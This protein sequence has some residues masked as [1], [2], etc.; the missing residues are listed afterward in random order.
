MILGA[1]NSISSLAVSC[2]L[3]CALSACISQ[4]APVPPG[5]IPRYAAPSQEDEQYGHKILSEL[6]K[7]YQLDY[8]HPRTPDV[9]KIV[10]KLAG[11]AHANGEPWHV[12]V[13]KDDNFKNAAASRGNHVFVWTGILN[14]T[15]D[16]DELAAII[17]HEMSHV[18]AKHTAK[19]PNEQVRQTLVQLGSLAAGMAAAYATRSSSWSSQVGDLASSATEEVAGGF[20]VNP[21]SREKEAEADQIGLFLMAD[22][23]YDPAAAVRFWQRAARDPSFGSS[24]A[25]FSTHPPAQERAQLLSTYL[26]Q[27]E[28]R[29]RGEKTSTN[30][31]A[32]A[33]YNR[34]P[35]YDLNASARQQVSSAASSNA[36]RSRSTTGGGLKSPAA[37]GPQVKLPSAA[38]SPASSSMPDPGDT[39]DMSKGSQTASPAAA[40]ASYQPAY[41]AVPIITQV[42]LQG[43]AKQS[44]S[45]QPFSTQSAGS[46]PG[47]DWIVVV[48]TA[49]LYAAPDQKSEVI[50]KFQ[51]STLIRV[52][53][54][55]KDWLEIAT[56]DH[57]Y[58]LLQQAVPLRRLDDLD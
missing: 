1:A 39:F 45:P 35:T 12:Y 32:G 14:A 48:P 53:S 19:D 5:E 34:A 42:D 27:A 52:L 24:L 16:N 41:K 17:A 6:T 9:Y 47:Q 15:Q 49:V 56:P 4:R 11:A 22:A 55:D 3:I 26:P 28:A 20:L 43:P 44:N 23:H 29:F 31:A 30:A 10:E 2:F 8:N 25:F 50:S 57:G 54:A 7:R 36:S 46:D 40:P 37:T 13:L 18:L 38:A 51:R 58:M 33:P 21:Y